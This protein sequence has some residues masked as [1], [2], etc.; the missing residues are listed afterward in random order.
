[1][2]TLSHSKY[3]TNSSDRGRRIV[4]LGVWARKVGYQEEKRQART[5]EVARGGKR[6]AEGDMVVR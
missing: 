2:K 6:G 3:L 5:S 1:M 4:A